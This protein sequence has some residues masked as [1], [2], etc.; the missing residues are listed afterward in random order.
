MGNDDDVSEKSSPNTYQMRYKS[1]RLSLK[2]DT[3][4]LIEFPYI[5]KLELSRMV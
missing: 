1:L 4:C 2:C 3:L 5:E